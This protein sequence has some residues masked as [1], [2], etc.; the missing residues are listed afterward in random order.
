MPR[1]RC[2]LTAP[3]PAPCQPA[4]RKFDGWCIQG[5][6]AGA[7]VVVAAAALAGLAAYTMCRQA[8]LGLRAE[9]RRWRYGRRVNATV[10]AIVLIASVVLL[11]R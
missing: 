7:V 6:V 4:G 1:R 9:P 2:S 10:A 5:F 11:V 8:L 3:R